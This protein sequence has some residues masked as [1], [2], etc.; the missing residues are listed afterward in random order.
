M[1]ALRLGVHRLLLLSL[2]VL[3]CAAQSAI[4]VRFSGVTARID[5]L[6]ALL[7]CAAAKE[8][9]EAG[10]ML[11]LF[12]SLLLGA[13]DDLLLLLSPFY[14]LTGRA[15]GRLA[16]RRLRVNLPGAALLTLPVSLLFALARALL[17]RLAGAALPLSAADLT[18]GI[19]AS[20]AAALFF[21]PPV[22]GIR[23]LAGPRGRA[24]P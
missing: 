5:L 1:R 12:T 4:G 10:G 17:A 19:A 16:E 3:T 7:V 15:V 14:F 23:R 24:L 11:G 21:Y 9:A 13:G 20:S 22:T 18:A 2:F 6:S 8:G